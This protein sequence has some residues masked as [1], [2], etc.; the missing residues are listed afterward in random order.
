[1]ALV[2]NAQ[3][4]SGNLS[5]S[6]SSRP[7]R[8]SRFITL[9]TLGAANTGT[10]NMPFIIWKKQPRQKPEAKYS[11][12]KLKELAVYNRSLEF[13]DLPQGLFKFSPYGLLR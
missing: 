2:F 13:P 7:T 12:N 1:M 5:N 11:T 4:S 8:S 3:V 6:F 9:M 10:R